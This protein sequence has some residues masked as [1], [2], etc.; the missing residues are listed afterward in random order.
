MIHLYHLHPIVVHFPIALLSTA[1]GLELWAWRSDRE[2]R[3]LLSSLCLR[4][5]AAA[6]LLAVGT[7][8]LAEELGPHVPE[9]WR[10]M[11]WHE[12]MG[13]GVAGLSVILAVWP[14]RKGWLYVS[15]LMVLL[16]FVCAAGYLGGRLVF[17]FGVAV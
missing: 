5:G 4:L 16:G 9:A 7:G 3:R 6:A 10:V 15:G 2:Q 1:I 13:F 11:E 17:E 12:R 8:L 14:W